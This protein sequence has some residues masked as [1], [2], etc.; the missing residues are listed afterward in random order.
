M[1][2][3]LECLKEDDFGQYDK[4]HGARPVGQ[5]DFQFLHR[6]GYI[7]TK[8]PKSEDYTIRNVSI[9]EKGLS[10][11]PDDITNW[12]KEWRDLWPKG[13]TS[14]G[15][16]VRADLPGIIK[17]L[18]NFTKK[19]GYSKEDIFKATRIYLQEKELNGWAYIK[20]ANYFIEK[21]GMSILASCCEALKDTN[22]DTSDPFTNKV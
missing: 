4:Y 15:Y 6:E 16:P 20:L 11:F 12:A 9:T 7:E 21:D 22:F 5:L 3:I 18:K 10:L 2:F 1:Y 17:K 8:I 14:G 19:Y 13:V